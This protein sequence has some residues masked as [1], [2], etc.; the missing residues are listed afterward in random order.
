MSGRGDMR[1]PERLEQWYYRQTGRLPR[2]MDDV[3]ALHHREFIELNPNARNLRE[4][5]VEYAESKGGLVLAYFR[6]KS[7][8]YWGGV[9]RGN[10]SEIGPSM[11]LS[12]E[13]EYTIL[14]EMAQWVNA[15]LDATPELREPP[16]E[17]WYPDTSS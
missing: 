14:G 6:Q 2:D 11:G 16:S 5:V 12:K 13:Q 8:Y 17:W 3:A 15:R 9:L 1:V 7:P 4:L 10:P